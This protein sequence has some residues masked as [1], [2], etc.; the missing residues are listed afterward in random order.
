MRIKLGEKSNQ[1]V[2]IS[3]IYFSFSLSLSI[4]ACEL[5]ECALSYT[6]CRST[7]IDDCI[8]I[9]L[10]IYWPANILLLLLLL[11]RRNIKEN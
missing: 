1:I 6:N 9:V 3:S 11:D 4:F 5:V 10:Y 2:Q 8:M 7:C